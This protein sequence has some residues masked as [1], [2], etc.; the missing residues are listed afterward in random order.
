MDIPSERAIGGVFDSQG[1]QEECWEMR[2]N[3]ERWADHEVYSQATPVA[4]PVCQ[5]TN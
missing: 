1:L 5:F 3:L 4:L 2:L